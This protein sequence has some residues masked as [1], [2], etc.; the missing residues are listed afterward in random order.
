LVEIWYHHSVDKNHIATDG[1]EDTNF[2][3]LMSLGITLYFI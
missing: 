3:I 1:S 2:I